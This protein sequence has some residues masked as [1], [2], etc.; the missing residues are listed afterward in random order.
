MPDGAKT[1][2]ADRSQAQIRQER[3]AAE[4]RSNLLKR[5]QQAAAALPPQNRRTSRTVPGN[6]GGHGGPVCRLRAV[7]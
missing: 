1:N 6:A 5:K 7:R 3:L 4:L 2:K